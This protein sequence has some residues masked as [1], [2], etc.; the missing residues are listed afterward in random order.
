MFREILHEPFTTERED[1][2]IA[3]LILYRHSPNTSF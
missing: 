3:L 2:P 1:V